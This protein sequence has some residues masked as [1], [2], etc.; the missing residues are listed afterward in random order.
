MKI[1]ITGLGGF[2]GRYLQSELVT[3]GHAV[4]GLMSD[5]T[6]AEAL[7]AEIQQ[8][9]PDWVVHLAG[10]SF[11]GHL[12]ADDFYRVNLIGTRHLLAALDACGKKPSCVLLASSANVY[13]NRRG[14]LLSEGT[15]PAPANDYALSKL[16]MEQMARM[17]LDKLPIVIARPFNY[18][19]RG[20]S[21]DFIVPKL[22]GHF[23]QRASAVELGNLDVER[24]FNDVRSVVQVYHRLLEACPVGETVNV[25]SGRYYSLRKVM[26]IAEAIT[27]HRLHVEVNPA[28]VR[29]NEVRKL[30]GNP[31]KLQ[32]LIGE[33]KMQ[34][35]EETLRWMLEDSKV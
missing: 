6:N 20:Q 27:G 26:G 24:E 34:P 25:C 31:A 2:T 14:R 17:W 7:A 21:L 23:V 30:Y 22:V 10:I 13:G 5:L 8:V 11:V 15:Q 35:L 18:T 19:G 12:E 9:Q 28:Y 3:H 32:R 1:L 16:A 4:V 33:L 29:A